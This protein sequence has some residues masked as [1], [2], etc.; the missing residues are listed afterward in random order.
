MK[1]GGCLVERDMLSKSH[2]PNGT[3]NVLGPP[4]QDPH[5]KQ[6]KENWRGYPG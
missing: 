6:L 2:S 5:W 3:L 4:T 1:H